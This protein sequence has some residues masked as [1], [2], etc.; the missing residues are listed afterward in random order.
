M[1]G[2]LASSATVRGTAGSEPVLFARSTDGGATWIRA[3]VP[4]ATGLWS[5]WGS[6][7][8]DVT[9]VG[10]VGAILRFDGQDW[11]SV[12]TGGAESFQ[13]QTPAG[14]NMHWGV[15]EHGM[16]AC[17]NGIAAHGGLRVFGSTFLVFSDYMKPA[18]R[19]AEEVARVVRSAAGARG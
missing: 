4:Q 15:R 6:S 12:G 13:A 14:R 16:A 3:R 17:M 11:Q 9:V 19:L 18:I 2:R 10:A 5:V 7:P 8:T 1:A